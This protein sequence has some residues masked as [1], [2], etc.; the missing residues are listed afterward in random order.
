MGLNSPINVPVIKHS[1]SE[2]QN[3][4]GDWRVF[5]E[6]ILNWEANWERKVMSR[7]N[8]RQTVSKSYTTPVLELPGILGH[9]PCSQEAHIVQGWT[10]KTQEVIYMAPNIQA[11]WGCVPK[12]SKTEKASGQT[13]GI[14]NLLKHRRIY[15]LKHQKEKI[16]K[17]LLSRKLFKYDCHRPWPVRYNFKYYYYISEVSFHELRLKFFSGYSI[18]S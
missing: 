18:I 2:N 1:S 8:W 10:V 5:L 9:C 7:E 4:H 3:V 15:H 13:T 12:C 11:E 16:Y 14:S 17:Y 6:G